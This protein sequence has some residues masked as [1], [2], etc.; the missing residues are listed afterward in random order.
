MN[1]CFVAN[2]HK[3]YL[4]HEV[5][6]RL[7]RD[8]VRVFWVV[9]N[10]KLR[11]FLLEHYD[12]D[13]VLYL[14]KL[15]A[16]QECAPV[17]DFRLNELVHGDRVLTHERSWAWQF[18][19]NIQ[20]PFH[21]F[22]AANEV[23]HVFG[24]VTWAHEILFHRIL[25]NRTELGARYLCPHTIRIPNGRFGFFTDE[26]QS[27]LLER[28][29][30][31]REVFDV[32]DLQVAKPDYLKI[33]D[34]RLDKARSIRSRLHRMKR[35]FTKENIDDVDPT[36]PANRWLA[37]KLRA[38]EEFNREMYRFVRTEP[39]TEELAA[40]PYILMTLHKQPEA[41]IDVIGRYYENQWINILNV[42]R[43]LPDG[44]RL[45]VKE[46]T[47]AIGDRSVWFYAKIKRLRNLVLIDEK[48]DSHRLINACKVVVTVSGTVAYEAALL[49]K[50]AY[51]FAPCFF[52]KL[53]GCDAIGLN[54]TR[55]AIDW[56]DWNSNAPKCDISQLISRSYKGLISDPVSS[57][58]CVDP[59]NVQSIAAAIREVSS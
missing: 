6:K 43:S 28:P 38:A 51:T 47:N 12:K 8:G 40:S 29:Q 44:W 18:L 26:F 25:T 23:K 31:S 7:Q 30:D 35:F 4:F 2:F 15:N 22:I 52:N 9:V 14:S 37:F 36:V 16:A 58:S 57:P 41:S 39:F 46:H 11:D 33:N 17:G 19:E 32:A 53:N 3:T 50:R 45:V 42:W 48:E 55:A 34:A 59:D 1:I 49:G 5:A 54:E 24:E 20:R 13:Q 21:D 10:R 56:L 27:E